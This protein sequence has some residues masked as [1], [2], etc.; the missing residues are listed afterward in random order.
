M[1]T[2][3]L[4]IGLVLAALGV[5]GLACRKPAPMPEPPKV[6]LAAEA[7]A[8]AKAE[9]EAKAAAEAKR[10]AEEEARRK[11]EQEK[12]EAARKAEANKL[13]A[14]KKAAEKALQDVHFDYDKSVIKE[15]DKAALQAL[16]DFM[17]ANPQ[18]KIQLEGHC[19]ERGTVEYNLALGERRAAATKAY[20]KAL[21][22]GDDRMD[23]ISY[24]KERPLCTEANE[25][26]WH[27]NRRAHPVL[28]G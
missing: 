19:D 28:K 26:C 23:T 2:N 10:K 12:A 11:A 27:R 14:Y 24:G 3:Y 5:G 25:G 4:A 16:A 22:V 6:D 1:R 9:A 13:A 21:G 8:K 15:E 18:A 7:A 20:L 17:R